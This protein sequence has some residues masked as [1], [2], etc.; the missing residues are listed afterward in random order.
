MLSEDISNSEVIYNVLLVLSAILMD[1]TGKAI[2]LFQD[3]ISV[4]SVCRCICSCFRVKKLMKD[5][6]ESLVCRVE[7]M[8]FC[9]HGQC[10]LGVK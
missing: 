8:T 5:G 3:S 2:S 9:S 10:V 4:F 1:N 6:K 7:S